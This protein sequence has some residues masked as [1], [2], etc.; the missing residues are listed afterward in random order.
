[1]NLRSKTL[2]IHLTKAFVLRGRTGPALTPT[3]ALIGSRLKSAELTFHN[4][5]L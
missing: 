1:M 3:V 4:T 2:S 5:T